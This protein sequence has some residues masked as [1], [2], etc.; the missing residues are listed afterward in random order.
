MAWYPGVSPLLPL[1]EFL[2]PSRSP[3][4]VS[5]IIGSG[6]V[7][8][9]LFDHGN[10]TDYEFLLVAIPV[11]FTLLLIMVFSFRDKSS[12]DPDEDIENHF[13]FSRALGIGTAIFAMGLVVV[14][15]P[16]SGGLYFYLCYLAALTQLI[17]FVFYS[18]VRLV[19]EESR[20]DGRIFQISFMMF[21]FLIVATF[22]FAVGSEHDGMVQYTEKVEEVIGGEI[23]EEEIKKINRAG[24]TG[25]VFGALWLIYEL[26]WI[27]RIYRIVEVRLE[28][29]TN[30]NLRDGSS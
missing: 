15:F 27:L 1:I 14:I 13:R 22:C 9:L 3:H 29:S 12:A 11:Y 19:R 6:S 28:V 8:F 20:N 23:K 4:L 26:F 21:I 2:R 16:Q 7:C 25:L 5:S 18:L 30:G 24:I 10:V 17:T